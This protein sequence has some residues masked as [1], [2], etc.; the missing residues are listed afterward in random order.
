ME[1]P[2]TLHLNSKGLSLSDAQSIS[3]SCHQASLEIDNE[4]ASINNTHKVVTID[5]V[6]HIVQQGVPR[7]VSVVSLLT[8]KAAY[9][10]TQALLMENMKVKKAWL[11]Q[12]E[13]SMVQALPSVKLPEQPKKVMTAKEPDEPRLKSEAWAFDQLSPAARAEY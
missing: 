13:R 4:L 7:P 10:A 6:E 12:I 11:E 9:A 5:G 3:N 2:N 1:T 8:K